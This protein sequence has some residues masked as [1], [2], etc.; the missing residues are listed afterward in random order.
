MQWFPRHISEL[1]LIANR[2]LDAGTD[3]E[4]DHPGFNDAEYRERRARLAQ[5][6]L[7]YRMHNSI[8]HTAYSKEEIETWGIVWDKMEDL[9]DK[10]SCIGRCCGTIMLSDS[11]HCNRF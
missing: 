6:A 4:A 10:V 9:W 1:D 8:P 5:Q 2:T 3:L 7:D 11:H